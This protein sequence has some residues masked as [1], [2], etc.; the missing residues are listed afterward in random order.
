MMGDN[1]DSDFGGTKVLD[2]GFVVVVVICEVPGPFDCIG[3][4]WQENAK[5]R[6]LLEEIIGTIFSKY[7]TYRCS[8]VDI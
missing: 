4:R 1:I 7:S 8:V 3:S 5:L 2:V 6:S